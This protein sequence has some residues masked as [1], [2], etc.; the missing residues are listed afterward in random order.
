MAVL[1]VVW[2]AW[3]NFYLRFSE[4]EILE[5]LSSFALELTRYSNPFLVSQ[6]PQVVCWKLL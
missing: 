6:E 1:K 4:T 5:A 2:P 3:S